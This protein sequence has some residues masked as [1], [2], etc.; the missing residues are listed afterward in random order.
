M[1]FLSP[2]SEFIARLG[3]PGDH[4]IDFMH[5]E[6]TFVKAFLWDMVL[7]HII[8]VGPVA[9]VPPATSTALLFSSDIMD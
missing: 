9:V 2:K 5:D 6:T 8:D 7:H 3:C 1:P 4:L